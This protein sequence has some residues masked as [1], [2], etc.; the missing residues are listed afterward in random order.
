MTITLLNI[1]SIAL[2]ILVLMILF[3]TIESANFGKSTIFKEAK[4]TLLLG[5]RDADL[6]SKIKNGIPTT[7][8]F[9]I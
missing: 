7:E 5:R 8:K 2:V 1:I 3:K 9:Y 6:T 4:S